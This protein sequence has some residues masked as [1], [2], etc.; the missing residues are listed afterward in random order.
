[1]CCR[2][3]NWP[4][5]PSLTAIPDS[6]TVRGLAGLVKSVIQRIGETMS[7]LLLCLVFVF[8]SPVIFSLNAAPL[9]VNASILGNQKTLSLTVNSFKTS[10]AAVIGAE[11][12]HPG[13]KVT[14]IKL[15]TDGKFWRITMK[16]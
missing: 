9:K 12:K 8:T 16:K 3:R 4:S 15:S 14:K 10:A 7:R 5:R 2:T 13:W 11:R 1:M 6:A